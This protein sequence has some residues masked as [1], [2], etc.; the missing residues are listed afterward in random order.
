VALERAGLVIDEGTYER[1]RDPVQLGAPLTVQEGDVLVIEGCGGSSRVP[2]APHD[3]PPPIVT[4]LSTDG[5]TLR[6]EWTSPGREP[7]GVHSL[8][9][10]GFTATACHSTG[11]GPGRVTRRATFLPGWGTL[12]ISSLYSQGSHPTAWGEAHV[13][14]MTTA[15]ERADVA[16]PIPADGSWW[17]PGRITPVVD[18][19]VNGATYPLG[20]WTWLIQPVEGG[21]RY[22]LEAPNLYARVT[23]SET[24][25]TILVGGCLATVAHAPTDDLELAFDGNQ[26]VAFATGSIPLLCKSDP[27][28]AGTLELS[29]SWEHPRIARPVAP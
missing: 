6:V 9:S 20:S 27:T 12:F 19:V 3:E 8:L 25:D 21:A 1:T 11:A 16:V 26:T 18:L 10:D 23:S 14:G 4:D 13:W 7:T 29:M 5:E 15:V 22:Q 2:I 24:T 28:T 17:D